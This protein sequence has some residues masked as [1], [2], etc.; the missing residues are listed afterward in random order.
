MSENEQQAGIPSEQS[1]RV[2]RLGENIK[3]VL[4]IA[5]ALTNSYG[6]RELSLCIIKLQESYFWLSEVVERGPG[7][8]NEGRNFP[9]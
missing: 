4:N 1:F 7:G 3:R 6:G 8:W 9:L 2:S 5:R